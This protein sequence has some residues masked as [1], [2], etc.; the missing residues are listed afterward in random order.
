MR[1]ILGPF[2]FWGYV[3][4]IAVTRDLDIFIA[5]TIILVLS[6]MTIRTKPRNP[7]L[8]RDFLRQLLS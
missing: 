7:E 2:V 1:D 6:V 5:V 8:V 3:L 4:L